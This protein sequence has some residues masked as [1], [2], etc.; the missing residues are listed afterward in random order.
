MRP[1]LRRELR[2]RLGSRARAKPDRAAGV[3][4]ALQDPTIDFYR[5]SEL[6]LSNDNWKSDDE[7]AIAGIGIP[8]TNDKEAAI[9]VTIDPGCYAAVI[10]GKNNTTGVASVEVYQMPWFVRP[11]RPAG[12]GYWLSA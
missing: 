1:T 5:D 10:R 9:L 4:G 11:R 6:I 3:T 12:L 2:R 8:S 7:T